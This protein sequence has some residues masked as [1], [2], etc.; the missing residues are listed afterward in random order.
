MFH[1]FYH[2][3]IK[4]YSPKASE[5][6]EQKVATHHIEGQNMKDEAQQFSFATALG[7]LPILRH[8]GVKQLSKSLSKTSHMHLLSL[9]V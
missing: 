9:V 3:K 8:I 2:L 6:L 7:T 4:H 1:S 5:R